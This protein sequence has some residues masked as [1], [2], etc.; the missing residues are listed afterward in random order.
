MLY[1]CV[2]PVSDWTEIQGLPE[3]RKTLI[4]AAPA[5]APMMMGMAQQHQHQQPQAAT[6]YQAPAAAGRGVRRGR[7]Q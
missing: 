4:S 3:L 2:R 6:Q 5:A 1:G 7:V